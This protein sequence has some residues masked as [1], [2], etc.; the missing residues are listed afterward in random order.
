MVCALVLACRT[1]TPPNVLEEMF[2]PRKVVVPKAPA[3]GLLLE[4]PLFESYNRRVADINAK[5]EGEEDPTYRPAI[6][7]ERHRTTIDQFKQE[8]IYSRMRTQEESD[9][10]Q[11]ELHP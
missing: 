1:G 11:V 10:T 2:G 7:F 6:D 4:Q 5:L 8:Q 3:L 9:A